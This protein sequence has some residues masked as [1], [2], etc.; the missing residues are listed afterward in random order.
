MADQDRY[1]KLKDQ[2]R[3]VAPAESGDEDLGPLKHLPGKW[4]SD[5]NGWNM[6]ALPFDTDSGFRGN[7]RVLMNQYREDLKFTLVDKG[8]PNRGISPEGDG[9]VDTDQLLVTLDYEQVIHQIRVD[10]SEDPPSDKRGKECEVNDPDRK[11]L[12]IHHEPGLWLNMTNFKT[13]KIDLARLATIPHG[14]SV[15]GLGES[16]TKTGRPE[17]PVLNGLPIGAPGN[18]NINHPYLAPYKKFEDKPF[19]GTAENVPNFPGFFT[20]DLNAILRFVQENDSEE[21]IETTILEVDTTLEDAGIV[22]IPFIERQ[23]DAAS[24]KSTFWIQELKG[25][26][27]H[28][29]KRFRL[30][31]SQVVMLDFFPR[32]DGLPGLIRWPHVSINTLTKAVDAPLS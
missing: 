12:A 27:D 1:E 29:N 17:I 9:F 23:A 6:I 19:K 4:E 5:Q 30:Q 26:D 14:N 20:T 10:G 15:L 31:Y 3:Y 18:G 11:C 13:G 32:A 7:F 21:V 8:V 28:D 16:D 24:M 22:N 2:P 25:L